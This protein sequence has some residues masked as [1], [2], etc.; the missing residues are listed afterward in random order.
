MLTRLTKI[1]IK[2]HGQLKG[3]ALY[4]QGWTSDSF[5]WFANHVPLKRG[6]YLLSIHKDHLL[7]LSQRDYTTCNTIKFKGAYHVQITDE[8]S[9]RTAKMILGYDIEIERETV[10]L[11]LG[12]SKVKTLDALAGD[13]WKL[14]LGVKDGRA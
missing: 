11:R 8:K 4:Y 2:F 10:Y 12:G 14:S 5:L 9:A 6:T 7:S 3:Q 13:L 1:V